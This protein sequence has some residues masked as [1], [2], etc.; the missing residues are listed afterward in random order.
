MQ[1]SSVKLYKQIVETCL[2]PLGK[3]QLI[4]SGGI[5]SVKDIEAVRDA[6]CKGVIIGKAIYE[7]KIKLPELKLFLR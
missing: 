2:L 7:G 3:G 6:G 1:G 4:A 5:S